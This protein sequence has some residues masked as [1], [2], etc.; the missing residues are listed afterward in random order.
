[1]FAVNTEFGGVVYKLEARVAVQGPPDG[2]QA[3]GNFMKLKK[4]KR[5]VLH[6]GCHNSR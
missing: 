2:L 3:D 5:K 4:G 6:L 1:M